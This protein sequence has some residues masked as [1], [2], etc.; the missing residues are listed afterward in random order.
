MHAQA[1]A[2]LRP[3]ILGMGVW[4]FKSESTTSRDSSAVRV[5]GV[6]NQRPERD[7]KMNGVFH[8]PHE[9]AEPFG[10]VCINVRMIRE[11]RNDAKYKNTH[12]SIERVGVFWYIYCGDCYGR[13]RYQRRRH[14]FGGLPSHP[15]AR[16][17][18]RNKRRRA[19]VC[20]PFATL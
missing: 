17:H 9:S 1:R 20:S 19:I 12:I 7:C 8:D 11:P 18:V 10:K 3:G 2:I 14:H 13:R 16:V 4:R 6:L 15:I 5:I